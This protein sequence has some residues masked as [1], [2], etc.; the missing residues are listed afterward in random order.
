MN[1]TGRILCSSQSFLA[2]NLPEEAMRRRHCCGQ[3]S[4]NAS[5]KY[6]LYKYCVQG[7]RGAELLC[8]LKQSLP[9]ATRTACASNSQDRSLTYLH[10]DILDIGVFAFNLH[11]I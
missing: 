1:L 6:Q 7:T 8:L 11:D 4:K 2:W 5:E 10:I 3:Y 9:V